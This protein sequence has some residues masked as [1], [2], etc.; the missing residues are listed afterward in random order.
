MKELLKQGRHERSMVRHGRHSRGAYHLWR[1][2]GLYVDTDSLTYATYIT[3]TCQLCGRSIK[4][5]RT[6]NPYPEP[7]L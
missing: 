5:L 3:W 4:R 2:T 1:R 6:P 7:I